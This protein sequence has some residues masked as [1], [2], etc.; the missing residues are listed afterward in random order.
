MLGAEKIGHE[1]RHQRKHKRNGDITRN[2]RTTREYHNQPQQVH[3]EDKEE[4]REQIWSETGGFILQGGLYDTY[5]DEIDKR[6][7]S[8]K[9]LSGSLVGIM[10]VPAREHQ[11]AGKYDNARDENSAHIFGD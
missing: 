10:T 5:I 2:V 6:L 9:A 7:E 11:A 1:E 8:T 3:E 4:H